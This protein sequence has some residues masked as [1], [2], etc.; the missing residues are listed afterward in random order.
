MNQEGFALIETLIVASIAF[1][2]IP[3]S[4]IKFSSVHQTQS[5]DYFVNQ[6]KEALHQAQITAMAK[7]KTVNVLID[8][9][10]HLVKIQEG[11]NDIKSFHFDKDIEVEKGTQGKKITFLK[12]GH[13]QKTGTIFLKLGKKK[14]RLVFLLGQGRY[15]FEKQ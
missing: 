14:Y 11:G 3:I 7:G 9:Q 13:I 4:F 8:D 1:I 15:Y 2:I 6:L 10:N 5:L 12:N